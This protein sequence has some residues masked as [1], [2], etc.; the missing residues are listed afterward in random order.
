MHVG[1]L[2]NEFHTLEPS[3]TTAMMAQVLAAQ[4]HDVAIF[5]VADI[6]VDEDGEP[7]A[8]TRL[9]ESAN[10]VA[11]VIHAAR[12]A[13]RTRLRLSALDRVLI[14]TNPARDARGWAHESAL[15]LLARVASS[16]TPVINDPNGL[17]DAGSK[18]FLAE[19]PHWTTPRTVVSVDRDVLT[20]FVRSADGPTVLKP[21]K[22]TRGADVFKVEADSPNLNVI[23]D[24]LCRQGLVMAQAFVP[25]AVHG[26]TRVVVVDGQVLE[27]DG[28]ALAIHRIPGAS[29]F[30]SNIHAGGRAE[31]GTV[32]PEMRRVVDAVGP[33]LMAKG[34][35]LAGLDFLGALLCEVNVFSTGGFQ[36]GELFFDRP[37]LTHTLTTL[38]SD[39][40]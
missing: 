1:L 14:R 9:A 5:G 3:Q 33:I 35:R 15:Q 32:T 21:I 31:P 24:V 36:D 4:G 6:G 25:E 30:R 12:V 22:G 28:A 7:V 20:D 37:F 18:L 19:L 8:A 26:D 17:R 13:P 39:P 27:I 10:S 2:I 38:L 29:E 23:L 34:I 16:G 11:D 40:V